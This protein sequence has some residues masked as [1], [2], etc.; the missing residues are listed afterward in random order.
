M[1]SKYLHLPI[2]LYYKRLY[3][4]YIC[5]SSSLPVPTHPT[6][7]ILPW[8]RHVPTAS[9]S[10]HHGQIQL[11][12]LPHQTHLVTQSKQTGQAGQSG[13]FFQSQR[14]GSKAGRRIEDCGGG[15]KS[16]KGS[17]WDAR[18]HSVIIVDC[19]WFWGFN[20]QRLLEKLLWVCSVENA[21]LYSKLDFKFCKCNL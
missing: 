17:K 18:K 15:A 21:T 14:V 9:M 16:H 10:L 2:I 1:F 12:L 8:P 5:R 7:S 19:C 3:L 6:P 4:I 11:H 13:H 20:A